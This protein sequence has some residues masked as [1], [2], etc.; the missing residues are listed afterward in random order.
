MRPIAPD[1]ERLRDELAPDARSQVLQDVFVLLVLGLKKD[2]YFVD[3]G[4]ADGINLSNTHL[5][6]RRFGWRGILV[7]PSRAWHDQLRENRPAAVL[8]VRAAWRESGATLEF[9]QVADS[10]LSTLSSLVESDYHRETRLNNIAS[11]YI[12]ETA[13]L[14]DMLAEH[15]APD[16]VD[17][18]SLD[19]EGSELDVLQGIPADSRRIFRVITCEHNHQEPRRTLIRSLLAERGYR[20][21]CPEL[22]RFDDWFLHESTPDP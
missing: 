17:Y 13:T 20:L 5:L 4:A 10:N 2:G 12:V 21:A 1:L 14:A 6:E 8:D 11:R 22:S 15:G 3:V 19:T 9:T 18:L 16:V 7:E